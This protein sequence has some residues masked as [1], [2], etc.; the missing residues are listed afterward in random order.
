MKKLIFVAFCGVLNIVAMA[1]EPPSS[2]DRPVDK[3]HEGIDV[4]ENDGVCVMRFA[5]YNDSTFIPGSRDVDLTQLTYPCEKLRT[6]DLIEKGKSGWV[7][8]APAWVMW[9]TGPDAVKFPKHPQ[10]LEPGAEHASVLI[11]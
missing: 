9:R 8:T 4:H 3:L 7:P 11:N 6:E 1:A 5:W 10:A 2:L